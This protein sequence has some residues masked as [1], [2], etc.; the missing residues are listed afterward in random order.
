MGRGAFDHFKPV[1]FGALLLSA[2]VLAWTET[3]EPTEA[4]YVMEEVIIKEANNNNNNI[5][6]IEQVLKC[7]RGGETCHVFNDP[8]CNGFVCIPPR[9]RCI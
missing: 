1:F 9:H 7:K 8:C 4:R 5:Q 6:V 3:D 2:T